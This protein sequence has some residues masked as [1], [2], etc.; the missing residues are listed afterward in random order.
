MRQADDLD[1]SHVDKKGLE[2]ISRNSVC[3]ASVTVS[4]S[5]ISRHQGV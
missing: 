5:G 1:G 3:L 4:A 2:T